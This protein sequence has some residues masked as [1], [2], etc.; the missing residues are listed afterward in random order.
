MYINYII[1][2]R[3]CVRREGKKTGKRVY[4]VSLVTRL[5]YIWSKIEF[6]E[7]SWQNLAEFSGL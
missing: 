3:R 4:I 7:R 1:K 6:K 5:I 2:L